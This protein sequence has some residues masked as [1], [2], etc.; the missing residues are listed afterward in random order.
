[1]N[2]LVTGANG[3]LGMSLRRMSL[4]SSDHFIFSDINEM[5]GEETVYLDIS[6]EE[7]VGI[8]ARSENV[9]LI[10]NCAAYT[11]VEKAESDVDYA[12]LLNHKAPGILAGTASEIGASMIHISTDYVF[13]GKFAVPIR[14]GSDPDPCNVYGATKLAGEN[15]VLKSGCRSIIIRT[16]WLYSPYGRNFVKTMLDLMHKTQSIKVVY[17]S[18]GSPTFAHDLAGLILHIIESG[19][20]D[21]TGIY[22][23]TDE[24]VASWYDL[25]MGVASHIGYT[26]KVTPVLSSEY[27]SA[28]RRP[29][30]SVL[31]KQLVKDTFGVDMPH[32]RD[33]LEECLNLIGV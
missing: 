26:G 17:D 21:K 1:M 27:P 28:V 32:W 30:Y 10:I 9:D 22:H 11:N 19:Q 25:A 6:N 14:E 15:A 20:L 4:Y 8:I 24:G 2:I 18:V 29:S 31:D 12:D 33:S 5:P 13:S 3:Q 16:A 7:A 23:F